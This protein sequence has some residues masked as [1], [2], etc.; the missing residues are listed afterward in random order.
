M[1]VDIWY[2]LFAQERD[3]IIDM[4]PPRFVTLPLYY[5]GMDCFAEEQNLHEID[6]EEYVVL[7]T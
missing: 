3:Y 4:I 7:E 6:V 5:D 2:G 1:K